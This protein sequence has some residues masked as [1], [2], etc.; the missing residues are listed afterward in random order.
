MA[1]RAN[2]LR[3]LAYGWGNLRREMPRSSRCRSLRSSTLAVALTFAGC[4]VP[5]VAAAFTGF[6]VGG[7][8]ARL[9]ND[10][11][12]VVLLRDG[13]RTVVSMQGHYRGPPRD[14]ALII[15]V[16]TVVKEQDV[17]TLPPEIFERVD[18]LTAPRLVE[19]WEQDPCGADGSKPAVVPGEGAPGSEPVPA[20]PGEGVAIE[21]QFA[22]GEY[23]IVILDAKQ[24]SGLEGW[25]A[26][27]GYVL[28]AGAAEV[29]PRYIEQGMKFFV[30]RVDASKLSFDAR[31]QARLSPLRFHYDSDSFG[32]P[33]RLGLAN[34]AGTQDLL[35]HIV[36]RQRHVA[37][38]V[39]NATI[40]SNLE[41]RDVARGSFAPFYVALFDA[42]REHNPGAVITEYAWQANSCDPC[43]QSPL[44]LAEL[45]TLGAD[46][47]PG[48]GGELPRGAEYTIPA[49]FVLTRLHARYGK[50][51]LGEDL[52]FKAAGPITGGREPV[53]GPL[54]RGAQPTTDLN[55]F[56]ARY[57]IRHRW[58]GPIDCKEPHR[59][60]WGGP[61]ADQEGKS[62]APVVARDLAFVPRDASFDAYVAQDIPEIKYVV[63]AEAERAAAVAEKASPDVKV[64]LPGEPAASTRTSCGCASSEAPAGLLG[65]GLA[66]LGLRR[67]RR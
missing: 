20:A 47:L 1:R 45:R 50:D 44:T 30:A 17:K 28:P 56:Q 8:K 33:V 53:A 60:R 57:V 42:T 9:H 21:A 58:T 65:L 29:L 15:P 24:A 3:V 32:L 22:V 52:V 51:G 36:A 11:T 13:T 6:Y 46:V 67:R 25:L 12:V 55:T 64:V 35:I 63:K 7:D 5:G 54:E 10:A 26:D 48:L 19:T 14:F 27:N 2:A 34:S 66:G 62:T 4:A 38:N 43:P 40:P 16:P 61:P 49:E 31:G 37:A 23:Q 18:Q 41:L 59:D 39:P